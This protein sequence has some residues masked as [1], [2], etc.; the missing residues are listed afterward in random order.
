MPSIGIG[1][2]VVIFLLLLVFV[3]PDRL[4]QVARTMGKVMGEV[5]RATD[6]LKNA[7]YL[8]DVRKRRMPRSTG[9]DPQAADAQPRPRS[10]AVRHVELPDEGPPG[11]AGPEGG[12]DD[13][14]DPDVDPDVAAHADALATDES[15]EA[16]E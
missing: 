6:E 12:A 2:L 3:G 14:V 5:R 10:P 16:K 13:D 7:L 4:P 15:P 8:E 11:P 1:E 9:P